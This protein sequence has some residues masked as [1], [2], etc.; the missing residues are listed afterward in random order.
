MNE[1]IET[2]AIILELERQR[3]QAQTSLAAIAG[4]LAVLSEKFTELEEL[5][6]KLYQ[7]IEALTK[8]EING[9]PEETGALVGGR[10]AGSVGQAR[11]LNS[12]QGENSQESPPDNQFKRKQG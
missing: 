7:E 11:S 12:S 1:N 10:L 5:N 8:P 9:V 6:K 4:Q 2:N 3:N